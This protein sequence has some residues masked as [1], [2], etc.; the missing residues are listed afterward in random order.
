MDKNSRHIQGDGNVQIEKPKF[1]AKSKG[2]NIYQV[3]GDVGLD[4]QGVIDAINN[5]IKINELTII[6]H[7][8]IKWHKWRPREDLNLQSIA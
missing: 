2:G 8:F 3:I 7:Q 6:Y 1:K 4:E 5:S